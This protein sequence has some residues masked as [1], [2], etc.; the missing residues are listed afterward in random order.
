M[1]G[2]HLFQKAL[3]IAVVF[4]LATMPANAADC[5]E[6]AITG[7]YSDLTSCDVT[8]EYPEEISEFEVHLDL[9]FEDSVID[10]QTLILKNLSV[11]KE[12]VVLYWEPATT[13]DGPYD[14]EVRVSSDNEVL[15]GQTHSFVYGNQ[16]L[17][18]ITIDSLIPNSEGISLAVTPKKPTI[19]NIE[20]MLVKDSRVVDVSVDEKVSIHTQTSTHHKQ[21]ETILKSGEE[22]RGR[23]KI[24][25]FDPYE[26]VIVDDK[27]FTAKANVE[28]T[29]TY[30]DEIGA[31]VTVNGISQVPFEG[32]IRFTL[33]ADNQATEQITV[34]VPLLLTG[35]DETIEAIWEQTLP[36]GE[37]TLAIEVISDTGEVIER[38]DTVI[39]VTETDTILD[40]T[41][42]TSGQTEEAPGFVVLGAIATFFILFLI[43][44]RK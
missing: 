11:S 17:P 23:A 24:Y 38:K 25:L 21:W 30:K 35:D 13:E 40:D 6:V 22:Y 16:V 14:V 10:S 29:D 42:D 2:H 28:I 44:N 15:C 33:Y 9:V 4:L 7:I 20:Y 3:L 12:T 34:D 1:I 8:I 18:I 5:D 41:N 19:A 39:D 37:Y 31:S 27:A 26:V 32:E 43:L 36:E